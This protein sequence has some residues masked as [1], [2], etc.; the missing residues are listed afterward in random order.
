ML[1]CVLRAPG[2]PSLALIFIKA[3]SANC[4]NQS[5]SHS[6]LKSKLSRGRTDAFRRTG[7]GPAQNSQ[8]HKAV[9]KLLPLLVELPMEQFCLDSQSRFEFHE[10]HRDTN[11]GGCL[12]HF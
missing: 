4:R 3:K 2:F 10:P 11:I 8:Q 7:R 5:D 6:Q 12:R 9:L 1:G